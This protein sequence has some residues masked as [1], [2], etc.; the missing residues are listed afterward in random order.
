MSKRTPDKPAAGAEGSTGAVAFYVYCVGERAA[1]APLVAGGDAPPA[2]EDASALE[3]VEAGELAAVVSA[4]PLSDYGEG[5]LAERI[6]DPAWTAL[7]VMGHERAVEFFSRRAGV[8]PLR[9][10]TIYLTRERVVAMIE[11]RRGA[12]SS[13]IE[14]LRGREEWGVNLYADRAR[15][16]ETI[17]TLSPRLRELSE[18]AAKASPGQGYLLRTK[19]EAARA[20]EARAETRRV[21]REVEE[22]LAAASEGAARL[23][24]HKDESGEHGEV[25]AKLAFLVERERFDAFRSAAERLAEKYDS[26]GF[27][28][29]LTGP[30]PA[31]NFA[32]SEQGN[33][34]SGE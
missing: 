27:R 32:A 18:Q 23:R 30:W 13:I 8:V 6:G 19:I 9:F 16:R 10:G 12:L 5:V 29:E 7:R 28:L 17:L 20:D 34:K 31:Y 2:I 4:V 11:G 3:V 15:L 14:R 33:G 22:T 21:A 25:A 26:L 1:L 24:V